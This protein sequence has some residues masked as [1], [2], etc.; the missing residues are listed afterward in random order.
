MN[1]FHDL[2]VAA[3]RQLKPTYCDYASETAVQSGPATY[4]YNQFDEPRVVVQDGDTLLV[5]DFYPSDN[6]TYLGYVVNKRSGDFTPVYPWAFES[7]A[8]YMLSIIE[9]PSQYP[10]LYREV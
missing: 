7:M 2:R 1:R 8:K 3:D 9:D 5:V 4:T 10:I 6:D